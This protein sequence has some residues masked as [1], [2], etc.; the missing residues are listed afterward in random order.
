[1]RG[2]EYQPRSTRSSNCRFV[3]LERSHVGFLTVLFVA[4]VALF[5]SGAFI[6]QVEAAQAR[7]PNI[8]FILT[9]NQSPSTLAIY[10]NKDTQ[11]PNIDRLAQEGILFHNA[12]APNGM[13]S[14]S[15]ATLLTGLMPSQ[16]GVHTALTD[17]DT[18]KWPKQW[19]VI[20]EFRTLPQTLHDAGYE[21]ALIG[22][23]HLGEPF[24][25]HLKFDYWLT[26]PEGHTWCFYNNKIIDNGKTYRY[27]GHLTEFWTNKAVD[28]ISKRKGDKPFFLFLSYDAPY[29][30]P[31]AIYGPD[32]N[33][34]Y[35]KLYEN[36]EMQSMPRVPANKKLIKFV[37]MAP[38]Y[39]DRGYAHWT[40]TLL[41]ALN[42]EVCARNIASQITYIDWGVG[43]VLDALKNKG[44]DKN[45]L[46]V[47]TSD[48]G[49]AYGQLGLFG[50]A[51]HS[52]PSNLY[53]TPLASPLIFYHPQSIPGGRTTDLLVSHYDLFPTLLDY[54]GL[55]S[56]KIAN[57]PGKSYAPLLKGEKPFWA[58]DEI[59]MEQEVSRAI[60]T[61]EWKYIK[62]SPDVIN[63]FVRHME[64]FSRPDYGAIREYFRTAQLPNFPVLE[65]IML[66]KPYFGEELYDIKNDPGET[67][68]LCD[69]PKYAAVKLELSKR[70]DDFF[71]QYA[72]PKYNLWKGGT[73]KSNSNTPFMWEKVWWNWKPVT[74]KEK[75]FAGKK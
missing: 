11:S 15:R 21:T 6:L 55:G 7:Y 25:P 53:D 32:K 28:W 9:D 2:K 68:N 63:K 65:E 14:P 31:P 44:F 72:A 73:C 52:L 43:Q 51:E 8:V 22:K 74:S 26:F 39:Y 50:Q 30:L 5:F 20:N 33:N 12:F 70:L 45:T 54:I 69:D 42:D 38:Q 34:P 57:T 56:I 27:P 59:F 62:R 60:R 75:P 1:M 24:H 16:H 40:E 3:R 67:K 19:C 37:T 17:T 35:F 64:P 47:F 66:S 23:Y 13:C 41:Y 61:S 10:G 46:I 36:K 71:S 49:I 58:R 4:T 18:L 48:Q 29:G